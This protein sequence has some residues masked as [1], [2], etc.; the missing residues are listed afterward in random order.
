MK[1]TGRLVGFLIL[2]AY[3]VIAGFIT[4]S[5]HAVLVLEL[6]S[7]LAV[8][9][10][11]V[12]MLPLLK[13]YNKNLTCGYVTLK[14]FEGLVMLA[15]AILLFTQIINEKGHEEIYEFHVYL[16]ASAF[17]L[18]SYLLYISRLVPRFISIWGMLGSVLMLASTILNMTLLTT[19]APPIVSH[20]PVILNEITLAIWLLLKGFSSPEAQE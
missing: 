5:P 2:A 7:G 1:K 11:A 13:P 3:S 9:A 8:I 16:F 17:L 12:V 18:L 19:P 15:A 4:S 10:M 6:L 20:L 14:T